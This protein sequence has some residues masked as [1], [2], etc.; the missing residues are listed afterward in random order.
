MLACVVKDSGHFLQAAAFKSTV[1]YVLLRLYR[2]L[3]ILATVYNIVKRKTA[4]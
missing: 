1:S 3:Q 2:S 4:R